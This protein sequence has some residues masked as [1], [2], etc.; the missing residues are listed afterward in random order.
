MVSGAIRR[1][2][3]A[4][5]SRP[6][7]AL[8]DGGAPRGFFAWYGLAAVFGVALEFGGRRDPQGPLYWLWVAVI[9]VSVAAFLAIHLWGAFS[10]RPERFKNWIIGFACL[11]M[12]AVN[13][14]AA[15]GWLVAAFEGV[16]VR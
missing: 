16:A 12:V 8:R 15:V 13:L 6:L 7:A 10:K 3:R 5:Y 11:L 4:A 14:P 9:P 1:A 2:A